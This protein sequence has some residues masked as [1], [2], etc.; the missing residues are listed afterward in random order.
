MNQELFEIWN[1]ESGKWNLIELGIMNQ[2]LYLKAY[3]EMGG[4]VPA[5]LGS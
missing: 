2:K 3:T 5:L 1:L 4:A